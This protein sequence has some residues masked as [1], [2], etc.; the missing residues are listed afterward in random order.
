MKL[1]DRRNCS[2]SAASQSDNGDKGGEEPSEN[3]EEPGKGGKELGEGEEGP[4]EA[5][6][7]RRGPALRRRGCLN[8][9]SV[10]V[11]LHTPGPPIQWQEQPQLLAAVRTAAED[12]PHEDHGGSGSQ[13]R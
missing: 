10:G 6:C 13:P 5:R 7:R 8:H 1:K 3:G 2:W 12:L 11:A 4:L 9:L